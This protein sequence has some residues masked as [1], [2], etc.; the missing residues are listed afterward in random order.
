MSRLALVHRTE[1]LDN[2]KELNVGR[3]G[4]TCIAGDKLYSAS[5]GSKCT[6]FT[7]TDIVTGEQEVFDCWDIY[8]SANPHMVSK[9]ED[10]FF[11]FFE[12]FVVVGDI[13]WAHHSSYIFMMDSER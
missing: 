10:I 7:I 13:I 2:I 11:Q 8:H 1:H 3:A 6:E 9:K 4:M 5:G 12:S